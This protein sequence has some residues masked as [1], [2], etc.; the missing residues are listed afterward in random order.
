MV[1]AVLILF[2]KVIKQDPLMYIRLNQAY[3][4]V[5][6][7]S[8]DG[9]LGLIFAENRVNMQFERG[10]NPF[11]TLLIAAFHSLMPVSF[12]YS[13]AAVS[14]IMDALTGL[15]D[16]D[17]LMM[18]EEILHILSSYVNQELGGARVVS[19]FGGIILEA[20]KTLA[21]YKATE[22]YLRF[23]TKVFKRPYPQASL[24]DDLKL[25]FERSL[26]ANSLEQ[27]YF[28]CMVDYFNTG[29]I[30]AASMGKLTTRLFK[31]TRVLLNHFLE[32]P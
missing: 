25:E 9:K 12:E 15:Y 10:N 13:R 17:E 29:F 5:A 1:E 8:H 14:H 31:L 4:R 7:L 19:Y 30:D 18:K 27:V 20:E 22:S 26:L 3:M 2:A 11:L 16:R 6:E 23:L 32:V 28:K 24:P 21:N